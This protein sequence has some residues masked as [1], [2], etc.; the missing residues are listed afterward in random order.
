MQSVIITRPKERLSADDNTFAAILANAGIQTIELPMIRVSLPDD[1]RDLDCALSKLA[2]HGYDYAAL[3]S[4]TATAARTTRLP[5][6]DH[7]T[8]RVAGFA[9]RSASDSLRMEKP[10]AR[11]PS[12]TTG[13]AFMF[14][15]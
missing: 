4:P 10:A 2:K 9:I 12:I 3:A 8:G 11:M 7:G 5:A 1:T 6:S 15:G 13:S 14:S